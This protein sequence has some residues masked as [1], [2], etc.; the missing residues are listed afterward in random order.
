[1][2]ETQTKAATMEQCAAR[3]I[4]LAREQ[5][6]TELPELQPAIYLLPD[7]VDEDTLGFGALWTDGNALRYIPEQVAREYRRD[8]TSIARLLLH[9]LTHGLLGHFGSCAGK[10]WDLFRYAADLETTDFLLCYARQFLRLDG[11]SETKW[12]LS[13][14]HGGTVEQIYNVTAESGV[15]PRRIYDIVQPLCVDVHRWNYYRTPSDECV[16]QWAEA[17]RLTAMNLRDA[18]RDDLAERLEGDG[19]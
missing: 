18:G 3:I 6:D 16:S 17:A 13:A 10:D 1:M 19:R 12:M 8:R 14:Q 11:P 5:L 15:D 9:I 4:E 2:T 7:I